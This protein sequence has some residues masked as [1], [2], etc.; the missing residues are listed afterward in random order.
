MGAINQPRGPKYRLKFRSSFSDKRFAK[1]P[2]VFLIS[3]TLPLDKRSGWMGI[4]AAL[5]CGIHLKQTSAFAHQVQSHCV[6]SR[7]SSDR[8]RSSCGTSVAQL[9]NGCTQQKKYIIIYKK[10]TWTFDQMMMIWQ[11][12]WFICGELAG[13]QMGEGGKKGKLFKKSQIR[14]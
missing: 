1:L 13:W 10:K 14:D 2:D 6:T 8:W 9:T 3:N 7:Q 5:L 12:W 4:P 11:S